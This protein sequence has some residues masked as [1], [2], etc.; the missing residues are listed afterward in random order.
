MYEC[1]SIIEIKRSSDFKRRQMFLDKRRNF[2]Y[3]CLST[4]EIKRSS[5]FKLRQL[6]L[7]K[8]NFEEKQSVENM[9]LEKVM[10]EIVKNKLFF[11]FCYLFIS[12]DT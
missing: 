2:M 4:T 6:F 1:L 10:E 3:E 9:F 8:R 5:D 11:L 12:V 7:D